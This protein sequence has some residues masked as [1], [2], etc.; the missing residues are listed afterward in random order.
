M[1]TRYAPAQAAA[2]CPAAP[3]P[4]CS[5]GRPPPRPAVTPACPLARPTV[6]S[7]WTGWLWMQG[8]GC[9]AQ[10]IKGIGWQAEDRRGR[11]T[12]MKG[13]A[14]SRMHVQESREGSAPWEVFRWVSTA[15]GCAGRNRGPRCC[16]RGR[17]AGL[18]TLERQPQ[19]AAAQ[20]AHRGVPLLHRRAAVC[21]H[22]EF[23]LVKAECALL[24]LLK[25]GEAVGRG[26]VRAA[27]VWVTAIKQQPGHKHRCAARCAVLQQAGERASQ[28]ARQGCGA[29]LTWRVM[30]RS[31]G[32]TLFHEA[33]CA[34]GT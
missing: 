15:S 7:V 31:T 10:L 26:G 12:D 5:P 11:G 24:L 20:Q 30:M 21:Q 23:G 6:C 27:A 2:L 3:R 28:Q 29:G 33:C 13:G 34:P 9:S 18:H 16:W 4:R 14:V 32:G 22:L 25:C 17:S 19:P 8:Y 1:T